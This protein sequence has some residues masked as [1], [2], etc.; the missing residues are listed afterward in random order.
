MQFILCF[1]LFSSSVLGVLQVADGSLSHRTVSAVVNP[2]QYYQS[3]VG[4]QERICHSQHILVLND[5]RE[6]MGVVCRLD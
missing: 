3:S 6:Q 4:I 1:L 2:F 5:H